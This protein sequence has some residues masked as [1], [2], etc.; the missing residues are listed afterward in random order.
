MA[1]INGIYA[2][3]M[4]ILN[5]DL[6]LNVKESILHAEKIIAQ[7]LTAMIYHGYF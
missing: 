1:K 6:S 4:S 3:G 7:Y 2:A 5:N